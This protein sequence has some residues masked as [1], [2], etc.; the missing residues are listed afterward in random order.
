MSNR[1]PLKHVKIVVCGSE[2]QLQVCEILNEII[3]GN[4]QWVDPYNTEIF[5]YK[6]WKP[7]LFV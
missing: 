1:H 2:T 7:K 4:D 5:L 6:P 3:N